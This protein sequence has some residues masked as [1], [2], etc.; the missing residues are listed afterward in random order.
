MARLS[1]T[2][3]LESKMKGWISD[4]VSLEEICD[5]LGV[6][7]DY[8][9]VKNRYS[10]YKKE[11]GLSSNRRERVSREIENVTKDTSKSTALLRGIKPLGSVNKEESNSTGSSNINPTLSEAGKNVGK[12]KSDLE[13]CD[14]LTLLRS[15][16]EDALKVKAYLKNAVFNGFSEEDG[17]KLCLS[18][19]EAKESI[20]VL[21]YCSEFLDTVYNVKKEGVK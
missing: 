15:C 6:P 16:T 18:M 14:L 8:T 2:E 3:E 19:R 9:S 1:W 4:G 17:T 10:R 11:L 7:H 21:E 12:T 13:G 5:K 20:K